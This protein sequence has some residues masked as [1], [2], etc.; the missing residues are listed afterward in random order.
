MGLPRTRRI[1]LY[2][3]YQRPDGTIRPWDGGSG[4]T[5]E[6]KKSVKSGRYLGRRVRVHQTHGDES[7][8]K[9]DE[10]ANFGI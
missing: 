4:E 1:I 2:A 9:A 6:V 3:C 10:Q 7:Q 8:V 5:L